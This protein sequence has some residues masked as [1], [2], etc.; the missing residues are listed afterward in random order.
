MTSVGQIE[1]VSEDHRRGPGGADTEPKSS[2]TGRSRRSTDRRLDQVPEG[3]KTAAC[4][5]ARVRRGCALRVV[6]R[7]DHRRVHRHE[8]RD[9]RARTPASWHTTFVGETITQSARTDVD[10]QVLTRIL[11]VGRR[12]V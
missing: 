12:C 1:D 10:Q 5:R 4:V 8:F 9:S 2:S 3:A 6:E 11:R 7:D